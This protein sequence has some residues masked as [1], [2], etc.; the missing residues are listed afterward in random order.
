M[1]NRKKIKN[2]IVI[3]LVLSLCILIG[4]D[5]EEGLSV[6]VEQIGSS[7][8]RDAEPK[9]LTPTAGGVMVLGDEELKIDV[10]NAADGYLFI[11]YQGESDDIKIQL[12]REDSITYTYKIFQGDTVIP[13]T[14]GAGHYSVIAYEGMGNGMYAARLSEKIEIESVDE[15][16]PF[17]YPNY[18]VNFTADSSC[19]Q[20]GKTLAENATC[21]LE[22]IASVYQYVVDNISYDYDLAN[23]VQSDYVPDVDKV[24]EQK[25]GICFDYAALMAAMLR[26]QRIPT[27]LEI[28]YAGDAYHAW[29]TTYI[30]DRGWINKVIEFDGNR[31]TLMDPTFAANAAGSSIEEFIGDGSNYASKYTY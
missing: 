12:A 1:S 27:R 18:Y 30:E 7:E 25:K 8:N 28:G 11:S 21:D 2:Y 15:F 16:G 4:C 5:K 31:W 14:L 6:K 26:S 23:S 22:V 29:I 20:L 3:F 13:L 9:C 10:T 17:L 24:L 19:V